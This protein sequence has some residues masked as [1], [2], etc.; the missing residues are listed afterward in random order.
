MR[1]VLVGALVAL[2]A[3]AAVAKVPSYNRAN[4][5]VAQASS[6][7]P[8]SDD[9]SHS[10]ECNEKPRTVLLETRVHINLVYW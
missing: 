9:K 8:G 1:V 7:K 4:L 5:S 3:V 10:V 6:E 2:P